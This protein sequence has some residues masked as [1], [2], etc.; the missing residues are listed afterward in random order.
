MNST[1]YASNSPSVSKYDVCIQQAGIDFGIAHCLDG[2]TYSFVDDYPRKLRAAVKLVPQIFNGR[3]M[4]FSEHD[5]DDLT[6]RLKLCRTLPSPDRDDVSVIDVLLRTLLSS[7][8]N[9]L[10]STMADRR[11]MGVFI[12]DLCEQ[13]RH[14]GDRTQAVA[15]ANQWQHKSSASWMSIEPAVEAAFSSNTPVLA[16]KV[17]LL[18]KTFMPAN[19][20]AAYL[21]HERV[22]ANESLFQ[23]EM[24]GEKVHRQPDILHRPSIALIQDDL[25]TL[26]DCLDR[27]ASIKNLLRGGVITVNFSRV[28]GFYL[29]VVLLADGR[30]N[31]ISKDLADGVDRLWDEVTGGDGYVHH[32]REPQCF[33]CGLIEPHNTARKA[34]LMLELECRALREKYVRA[35]GSEALPTFTL[36][37]PATA[38]AQHKEHHYA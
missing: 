12:R 5:L 27:A 38:G 6:G 22:T 2:T 3:P 36:I 19:E 20:E 24:S 7:R 11:E 18:R 29:S 34:A 1:S 8:F 30:N 35:K 10:V 31:S 9:Q 33:W 26:Q 28:H 13:A 16:H 32:W 23:Q 37:Q 25:H 17:A 4:F 14:E 15:R 21:L